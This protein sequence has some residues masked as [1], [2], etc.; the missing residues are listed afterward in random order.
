MAIQFYLEEGKFSIAAR[1]QKSVAEMYENEGDIQNAME[2]YEKAAELHDSE[3]ATAA[4]NQCKLK[5]AQY[6][7]QLEQYSKAIEIYERVASASLENNLLK[8]SAKDYFLRAGICQLCLDVKI[9]PFFLVPFT[10]SNNFYFNN[11]FFFILSPFFFI[12]VI[13]R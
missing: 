6:A 5:V 3:N 8:W 2:Q 11:S 9:F 10:E 7:A 1:H 13:C 4:S 12:F